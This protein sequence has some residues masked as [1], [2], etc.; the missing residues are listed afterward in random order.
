MLTVEYDH[1]SQ[2]NIY[3]DKEGLDLLLREL[4]ILEKRGGHAH[5]MTPSWAGQEL[6]E[7]RHDTSAELVHHL[8]IVLKPDNASP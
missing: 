4:V 1:E 6:T 8:R 3:C 2:V 7:D 5:L